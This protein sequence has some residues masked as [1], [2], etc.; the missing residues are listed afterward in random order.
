MLAAHIGK[1]LG[2]EKKERKKKVNKK[3]VF[4]IESNDEN[5]IREFDRERHDILEKALDD[6]SIWMLVYGFKEVTS[7]P[8]EEVSFY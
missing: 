1:C 5:E 3:E 6:M 7:T 4:E 8:P 2:S